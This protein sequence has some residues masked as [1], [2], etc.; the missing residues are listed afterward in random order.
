MELARIRAQKSVHH[1]DDIAL[2]ILI[3]NH[4]IRTISLLYSSAELCQI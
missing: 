1:C 4:A 2:N 3:S